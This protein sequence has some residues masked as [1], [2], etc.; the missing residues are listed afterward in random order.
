MVKHWFFRCDRLGV[1]SRAPFMASLF[2]LVF[3]ILFWGPWWSTIV[4]Y[5]FESPWASLCPRANTFCVRGLA[6]SRPRWASERL[7]GST[8]AN[9]FKTWLWLRDLDNRDRTCIVSCSHFPFFSSDAF[10]LSLGRSTRAIACCRDTGE[11]RI[12]VSNFS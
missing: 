7:E 4:L 9:K 1:Y 5:G 8:P 2:L 11:A 12:C 3:W 6:S 10:W